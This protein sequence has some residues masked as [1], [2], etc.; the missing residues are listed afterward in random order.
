MKLLSVKIYLAMVFLAVIPFRAVAAEGAPEVG[1]LKVK[2]DTVSYDKEKDFLRANG[3]VE[4]RW[5]Q[6]TLL[7]DSAL[8]RK[9]E[10]EAIAEGKVSL[11]REG[12]ILTSDRLRINYATGLGEAENGDLFIKQR[13]FHMRG[14]RFVK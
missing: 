4:I 12:D 9:G 2:A 3:N 5:D 14:A 13:N 1:E 11:F 7:S 8:V 10:S 6:F